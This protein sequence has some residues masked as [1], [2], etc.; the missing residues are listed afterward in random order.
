MS[1]QNKFKSQIQV[2]G[3]GG[4]K[5]INNSRPINPI[6][7]NNLNIQKQMNYNNSQKNNSNININNTNNY[8]YIEFKP[9]SQ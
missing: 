2:M 6:N 3:K 9:Y 4:I 1:F 7:N 8:Q 5:S